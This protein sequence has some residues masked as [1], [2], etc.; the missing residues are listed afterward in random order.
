MRIGAKPWQAKR[1]HFWIAELVTKERMIMGL[2]KPTLIGK[3]PLE[4]EALRQD[5]RKCLKIGPC[6]I[7]EKALY[8]NSFFIDR[9]YYVRYEDVAR[10]WKRVAMSKGGF[11]GKGV[12][13]SMAY[14][15]VKLKD[16][17]EIQC[18]FKHEQNVDILLARMAKHHPGIPT[19]SEEAERKLQAAEREERKKYREH[20]S[21]SAEK[22]VAD[23]K[24]CQEA[25]QIQPALYE[26]LAAA[27][28]QKRVIDSISSTYKAVALVI[29]LLAMGAVAFGVYALMQHR[30]VAIYFV[31]FGIAFMF[32]I[33]A[34]GV[35]PTGRRNK[36]TAAKE[37]EMAKKACEN[38]VNTIDH[39]PIPG[40]YA[41]PIVLERMIRAIRMGRCETAAEAFEMVKADLKAL[42]DQVTV[43]QKEYDEVVAVKPLFL[44]M[45]YQ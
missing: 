3:R 1:G 35:L 43:S 39:F 44:V 16:G 34:A 9:R 18:N 27:A 31:L 20:L 25:L 13:G 17:R 8:L 2:I 21:E 40:H 42:N 32:T 5:R 14:F 45:A 7:G 15:V 29:L 6:G 30:G 28:R 22:A 26:R 36:R 11:T 4:S 41:H 38:Y 37:Y 23:L 19:Q 33:M 10:V 24:R 12:F